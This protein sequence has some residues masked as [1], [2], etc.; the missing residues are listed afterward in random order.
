[1]TGTGLPAGPV[2]PQLLAAL[3]RS[4]RL[5]ALHACAITWANVLVVT[6][7]G[8]GILADGVVHSARFLSC[9]MQGVQNGS[10]QLLDSCVALGK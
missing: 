2:S 1:M 4:P 6:G 8:P 10:P 7:W 5:P 3:H 9:Y